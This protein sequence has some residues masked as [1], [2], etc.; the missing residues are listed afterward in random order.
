MLQDYRKLVDRG[1]LTKK[2]QSEELRGLQKEVEVLQRK[3]AAHKK[4][5]MIFKEASVLTQTF[6]GT[7]I[8]DIVTDA[9]KIVFPDRDIHFNIKFVTTR[10]TQ[11]IVEMEENG[12]ILS[13]FDS[14]GYGVLDIISISLRAAYIMLDNSAK[15]LILDE[16]FRNL[17][18]DRH[19]LAAKMLSGLS[20][21]LNIQ[22]I[23][24][25]HLLHI[26]EYADSIINVKHNSKN[27]LST[28]TVNGVKNETLLE[29]RSNRKNVFQ[30]KARRQISLRQKKSV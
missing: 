17:S 3:L 14:D 12:K 10:D 29:T 4:I 19:E 11:C 22:I 16:P 27:K 20:H 28:V 18:I 8:Q 15:L 1:L 13:L 7:Y 24:N 26:E 9:I 6:M 2:L 23:I 30:S 21:K 5:H 25:T